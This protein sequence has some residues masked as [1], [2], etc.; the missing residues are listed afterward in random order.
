[1]HDI[2]QR[3]LGRQRA[4]RPLKSTGN[5]DEGLSSSAADIALITAFT[6]LTGPDVKLPCNCFVVEKQFA[7]LLADDFPYLVAKFALLDIK[8]LVEEEMQGLIVAT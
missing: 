7:S 4:V 2:A 1:M 6:D 8:Y 3:Q 5:P